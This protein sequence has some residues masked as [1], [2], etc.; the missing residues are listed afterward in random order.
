M[1]LDIR[2]LQ[3]LKDS[4]VYL[5]KIYTGYHRFE[6]ELPHAVWPF[7]N[8][9]Q[10]HR[11]SDALGKGSPSLPRAYGHFLMSELYQMT[12]YGYAYSIKA[13]TRE[14]YRLKS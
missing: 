13:T 5:R 8:V 1:C 10:I 4:A 9:P 6:R 2:E 12:T 14:M 3:H 7:K 11:L